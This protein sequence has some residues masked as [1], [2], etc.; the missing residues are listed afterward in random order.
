MTRQ[1]LFFTLMMLREAFVKNAYKISDNGET[2]IIGIGG[3][4]SKVLE[5]SGLINCA[6]KATMVRADIYMEIVPSFCNEADFAD[7][8]KAARQA[9][10]S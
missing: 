7:V 1:G 10:E 8:L 2:Q 6:G 4:I 3:G 5:H 9:L